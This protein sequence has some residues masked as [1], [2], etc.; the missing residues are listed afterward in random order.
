VT[1]GNPGVVAKY[2]DQN[3]PD[4]LKTELNSLAKSQLKEALNQLSPAQETQLSNFVGNTELNSMATPFTWAGMDR[5]VK[6]SGQVMAN[7]VHQVSSLKQSFVQLFGNKHRV[8]TV[9]HAIARDPDPKHLPVSARVNMGKIN[10]WI[11]GSAGRFSQNNVADPS[12]LAV[13]GLDGSTYDTSI[14]LDYTLSNTFKLGVTTGYGLSKYKMKGIGARGNVDSAR[15][16][17]YGLWQA[18][19]WYLNGAASYGHHRFKA[20]RIMTV[21]PAIAH[22]K[23]DGHHVS[24]LAEVGKDITLTRR[25][26]V[27]TPYVSV[28]ALF[29]RENGYTE[30]GAGVQNVAVKSRNS[31]AV[32]GKVGVQLANLWYWH[33]E[34]SVYSFAR[35]GI[36][37]RRALGSYQKVSANLVGQGGVFTVRT[38]NKNRVLANPNIGLTVTPFKGISAT[39]AYEGDIGSNQR[40]HQAL[41]RV[42]WML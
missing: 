22:H 25:S 41:V 12:G 8:R 27:M 5:L 9:A 3:A 39:L 15:F 29:M 21:I 10:L 23:H 6:Q 20:N 32:Q 37:Y 1:I 36:T 16:S 31:T 24:G 4:S 33:D 28:G 7:L 42:N 30:Q 26:L 11:Q 14:G 35:L 40:N 17:L 38:R 2:L 18:Q 19:A 13:Q 34:T